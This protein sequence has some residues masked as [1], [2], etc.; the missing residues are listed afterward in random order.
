MLGYAG[1]RFSF[2]SRVR[3][4]ISLCIDNTIKL[5][6]TSVLQR[7]IVKGSLVKSI[8][9]SP[10]LLDLQ[11]VCASSLWLP[12]HYLLSFEAYK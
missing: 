10:Q 2:V 8:V 7:L 1:G 4:N 6:C 9:G 12:V 5:C 11:Y 3:E